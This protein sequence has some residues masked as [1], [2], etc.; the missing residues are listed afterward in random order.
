MAT[1]IPVQFY[2]LETI[3][4][5]NRQALK[6]FLAASFKKEGTTMEALQYI[7]CSDQYLLNINRQ[8]LQH[9][10]YTDIITFNLAAPKA[11]VN[12]E[13]YISIDRIKDNAAQFNT[14]VRQEL[15]R[16]IFHGALHLCGY[17]DKTAKEEKQMRGKEEEWLT[18][19]EKYLR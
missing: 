14:S 16:V 5:K 13:I 9:D 1:T 18:R 8:Y 3:A 17:R 11:P 6:S 12:G 19:Y 10:Y 15:H 7:F 2:F 4:L